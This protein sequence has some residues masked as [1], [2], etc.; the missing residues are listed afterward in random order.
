M[1][2]RQHASTMI[3][4]EELLSVASDCGWHQQWSPSRPAPCALRCS[5][6]YSRQMRPEMLTTNLCPAWAVASGQ[7]ASTSGREYLAF[8]MHRHLDFRLAETDALIEL[9]GHAASPARWRLPH[10]GLAYSPFWYLRLPSDAVARQVVGR[11]ILLKVRACFGP[12]TVAVAAASPVLA[13]GL[14][15]LAMHAGRG[16][17]THA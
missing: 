7:A 3:E 16:Q 10:G 11:S 12:A 8:F 6:H 1:G 13:H 4:V 9:A 15:R 14:S 2:M 17:S 5:M